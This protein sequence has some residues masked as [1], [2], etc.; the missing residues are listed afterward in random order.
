MT[1]L[2]QLTKELIA[3]LVRTQS[4]NFF[5]EEVDGEKVMFGFVAAGAGRSLNLSIAMER[6]IVTI[7]MTLKQNDASLALSHR[8]QEWTQLVRRAFGPAL[9]AIDLADDPEVNADSVLVAVRESLRDSVQVHEQEHAFGCTLFGSEVAEFSIGPVR[10]EARQDWLDRKLQDGG[11]ARLTGE[12]VRK[13][14]S[15][16]RPRKRK[17]VFEQLRE[18]NI[19]EAIGKCRYVCTVSTSGLAPEAGKIK[20]QMGARLALTAVSLLWETPSVTLDGFNLLIDRSVRHQRSLVFVPGKE[21]LGGSSLQ[22]RPEGPRMDPN[23]WSDLLTKYSRIFSTAGEAITYYLSPTGQVA[24]PKLMNSLV[25][26]MIWFHEACRE[27]VDLMAIVNFAAALDAMASGKE[28][29]G[30]LNLLQ[31][32]LGVARDDKFLPNGETTK[33]VVEQ[34]YGRGRSRAIHG[35]NDRIGHDWTSTRRVSEMVSRETLLACLDWAGTNPSDDPKLLS[36]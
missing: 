12:R 1:T 13:A 27:Q 31:A 10:F 16:Q 2:R 30:I 25:Q 35:T 4:P 8:D 28:S 36:K 34:I 32:R 3:E 33:Q 22:G 9:A 18:E 5:P 11:I 29:A 14:W 24:R 19:L 7:A 20:A 21:M 23:R 15:R 26:A 17:N 6:L